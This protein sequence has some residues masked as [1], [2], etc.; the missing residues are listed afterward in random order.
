MTTLH[1]RPSST[2]VPTSHLTRRRAVQSLLFVLFLQTGTACT[3]WRPVGLAPVPASDSAPSRTLR[4]ITSHGS[5]LMLHDAQLRNDTLYAT[6]A[7]GSHSARGSTISLPMAN[8]ADLRV[9]KFSSG[10]TF[11]RVAGSV[12]LA[13]ILAAAAA[14]AALG[15]LLGEG[16]GSY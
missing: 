6:L 1:S 8:V 7:N 11:G 14:A 10:K 9:R 16:S 3:S 4:V 2:G 15:S 12:V 13:L 5:Q